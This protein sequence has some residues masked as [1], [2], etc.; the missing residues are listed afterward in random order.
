[1]NIEHHVRN[2]KSKISGINTKVA[3]LKKEITS[4]KRALK[5]H[6]DAFSNRNFLSKLFAGIPYLFR[7]TSMDNSIEDLS[8]KL[9]LAHKEQDDALRVL[10]LESARELMLNGPDAEKLVRL[11]QEHAM[12]IALF[13]LTEKAAVSGENAL[14]AIQSAI[15]SLSEAESFEVLD[16]VTDSKLIS[17][18][19]T[20]QNFSASDAT[21]QV[22]QALSDFQQSMS[23]QQLHWGEIKHSTL[24]ETIDFA[25]DMMVDSSLIDSLGS[26]FS[27]ISLSETKNKLI[28]LHE[29]LEPIVASVT[30]EK[31]RDS[32]RLLSH[33]SDLQSLKSNERTKVI[34]LLRDHGV[35]V[36]REFASSITDIYAPSYQS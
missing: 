13:D 36:T 34:P 29:E 30:A 24:M 8:R 28:Q 16:A 20:I 7:K 33:E 32:L 10:V 15:T 5:T 21:E 17:S 12:L 25:M 26:L 23:E 27:L 31:K 6:V 22:N 18:V 3:Q 11:E 14:N 2:Y 35:E 1:M 19:S 4:Y 9:S